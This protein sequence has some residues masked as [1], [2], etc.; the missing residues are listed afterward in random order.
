MNL[1]RI[2]FLEL[3]D[4]SGVLA[5]SLADTATSRAIISLSIS[6][7]KLASVSHYAREP[8]RLTFETFTDTWISAYILSGDYELS[9]YV[10]RF[11][12]ALYRDEVLIFSGI[13]DT[14]QL[15]Y[16]PATELVSFTCYDK[17]KLLSLFSDIEYY[18]ALTA[19]YTPLWILT[20]FLT[21]IEANIDL[22]LPFV[23]EFVH[24]SSE[25]PY[26]TPVTLLT[27]DYTDLRALPAASGN[28]TYALVSPWGPRWG[29]FLDSFS[30][31][32][33]FFFA[34]IVTIKA[35]GTGG[36]G[37]IYRYKKRF[38]GRRAKF[39]NGT[40]PHLDEYDAA[41]EWLE[42]EDDP[43]AINAMNEFEA[44]IVSVGITLAA[45]AGSPG[46]PSGL[47][48]GD[49]TYTS[50]AAV[51][52]YVLAQWYGNI[53]P[54]RLFPGE[55][56]TQYVESFTP[57]LAAN[58]A[59]LLTYNATLFCRANGQIVLANKDARE[60]DPVV[61]DSRDLLSLELSR[62]DQEDPDMSP[63]D[64]LAGDVSLLKSQIKTALTGFYGSLWQ[65]SASIR[66]LDSYDLALFS[67]ITL[68]A[69]DYYVTELERDFVSDLYKVTA[70]KL[71]PSA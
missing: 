59:M 53:Y 3:R 23:S 16:D 55:L 20:T 46:L 54:P 5:H 51:N 71:P 22:K 45:L 26:S 31:C 67:V 15:S 65:A 41:T 37:T 66:G 43:A 69:D 21:K 6:A 35:T 56:Y 38:R 1:F 58:Q 63:L 39:Y 12:V 49:Q 50:S 2:D 9:R 30:N 36:A 61:I 32:P 29:W 57:A 40:S 4:G 47:V 34:E 25:I 52:Q 14:S 24:P 19:G 27:C 11:E 13:I 70:W 60:R 28:W 10:S 42:T 8:R 62:A 18:Y 48:V 17:L 33:W 64:I 68:A 7:D 44:W